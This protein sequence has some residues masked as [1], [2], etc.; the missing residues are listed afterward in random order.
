LENMFC[1]IIILIIDKAPDCAGGWPI[2]KYTIHKTKSDSGKIEKN[3]NRA[4]CYSSVPKN[5]RT[6]FYCDVGVAQRAAD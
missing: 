2:I 6:F 3:N 5:G 1:G 4:G